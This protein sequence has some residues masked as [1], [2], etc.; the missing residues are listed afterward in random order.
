MVMVKPTAKP[1][2]DGSGDVLD[3]GAVHRPPRQVTID[4]VFYDMLNVD[5]LGIGPRERLTA[6]IQR[7]DALEKRGKH[8]TAKEEAEYDGRLMELARIIL[9]SCPRATI[10]KLSI[11]ARQTLALD[12]LAGIAATTPRMQTVMRM[13]RL[14]GPMSSPASSTSTAATRS[15]GTNGHRPR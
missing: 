8:A 10:N 4:G 1:A 9:P 13:R 5:T 7:I 3:L 11:G 15:T 6:I 2:D 14:R 12:F